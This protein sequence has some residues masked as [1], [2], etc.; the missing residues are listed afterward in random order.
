[1][2]VKKLLVGLSIGA[3]ILSGCD[4]EE[5]SPKKASQK[6]EVLIAENLSSFSQKA[7]FDIGETA[8]SEISAY[9]SASKRLFVV[10]NETGSK[11]EVLDLSNF[12]T[13][14]KLQSIDF[15]AVSGG[16][17]SVAVH[18][19]LL[20]VA[21][22]GINKQD[23]GSIAILNTAT[24]TEIARVEAGALPDMVTFSPDGRFIISAN[25]GEPSG[26]Y[27]NDPKGSISIIDVK[28][29]SVKT[30]DFSSFENQKDALSKKHFRVFGLNASFAQDIEPEYITVC[31]DSKKAWVTLQE[32][33]GV[34]EINLEAGLITK[35]IPLGVKDINKGDYKFDVSDKDQ[36]IEL[37]HHPI[38]AYYLP[39]AISYFTSKNTGYLALANEGDTR[40]YDTFGEED[41]VKDLIL[42]PIRFPNASELQ[43]EEILGRLTVTNLFGDTDKDGDFDELYSTGGR[44]VSIINASTGKLVADIGV[45]LEERV[46]AAGKYDDGRSDNKG[47]E[48][49]AV[50]VAE[51]NGKQIC[52]IG[53]ERADMIAVYNVTN[54]NNP[55]FLQIFAT[56]DAPEGLLYIKPED[57]PNGKSLL[58][59]SSEGDGQVSFYQ[60]DSL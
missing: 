42:D 7:F 22:E 23:N 44:S 47:V 17:N 16:A 60:P 56:G 53:M 14:T 40:E 43:K 38:F 6:K 20:A 25:E 13:V 10:N 46:I 3:I 29:K 45:D 41:R 5:I 26:D 18:N 36:K 55:Q 21:L 59:V 27:T 35:I 34:A 15:A 48:V 12:P 11:V 58:V 39:D 19:G 49:E 33:N 2:V 9:D 30:I 28:T 37:G 32:N 31:S 8:A 4:P 54:P 52:F 57:S 1:M 50:T 51:I 24:L